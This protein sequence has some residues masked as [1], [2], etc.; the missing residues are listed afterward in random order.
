MD[1]VEPIVELGGGEAAAVEVD[2]DVVHA[3]LGSVGPGHEIVEPAQAAVGGDGGA[4]TQTAG[5]EF[6][7]HGDGRIHGAI[8][9]GGVGVLDW[10]VGLVVA[11]DMGGVGLVGRVGGP[12]ALLADGHVFPVERGAQIVVPVVVPGGV[13]RG[14]ADVGGALFGDP[15]PGED[16]HET[17]G[18]I[19]RRG[20]ATDF[21]IGVLGDVNLAGAAAVGLGRERR[22][23]ASFEFKGA[24]VAVEGAE[25]GGA[26]IVGVL[27][28]GARGAAEISS[29]EGLERLVGRRLRDHHRAEFVLDDAHVVTGDGGGGVDP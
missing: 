19:H 12:P 25:G 10:V 7:P 26:V 15:A 9:E 23:V 11:E 5:E 6:W 27:G 4:D 8:I 18:V 14:G 28:E 13:E 17:D 3:Q 22:H 21:E 24:D 2:G 16:A 1:G 20:Q 29:G